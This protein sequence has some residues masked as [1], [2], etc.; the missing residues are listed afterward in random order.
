MVMGDVNGN[1]T[2]VLER[3]DVHL[4]DNRLPP[5]GFTTSHSV[6]DTVRIVGAAET[7]PDFNLQGGIEGSGKDIIRY[8]VALNGYSG[9]F[10]AFVRVHYQAVPP[11]WL[12]E[13]RTFDH[14]EINVFLNMYDESENVPVVVA[15]DSLTEL[16]SPLLSQSIANNIGIYPN[17]VIE[18]HSFSISSDEAIESLSLYSLT[19]K[20]IDYSHQFINSNKVKVTTSASSGV[21]FLVVKTRN[22]KEIKKLI[23][24][25]N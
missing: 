2:T 12:N 4:K 6:Y 15:A 11:S 24:T 22:T 1:V 16:I 25:S 19:G 23:I 17:P 3:A 21:Y 7:D 20:T 9:E 5:L 14:E 18:N 8:K 13:M 10:N